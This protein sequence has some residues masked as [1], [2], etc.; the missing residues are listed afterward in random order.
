MSLFRVFD[1]AATALNA[2]SVRMNTDREIER[3]VGKRD[4]AL[5]EL[6]G[7]TRGIDTLSKSGLSPTLNVDGLG[8]VE[9]SEIIEIL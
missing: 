6:L 3:V 2:Q 9:M 4:I 8:A 1:I 5:I 7:D